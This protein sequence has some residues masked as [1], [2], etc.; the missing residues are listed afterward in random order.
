LAA[1]RVRLGPKEGC[2][3]KPWLLVCAVVA[4]AGSA[5][6]AQPSAIDMGTLNGPGDFVQPLSVGAGAVAWAKFTISEM[7][8]CQ[9]R[10][11]DI[12]VQPVGGFDTEIGLYDS[13]GKR[14]TNDDDDG[15]G[16][17]SAL[18]FGATS[19]LRPLGGDGVPGDGR[20][21]PLPAGTYYLALGEFNTL[22]NDDNWDVISTSEGSGGGCNIHFIIGAG[23]PVND[24]ATQLWESLCAVDAGNLPATARRADGS[25]ALTSIYGFGN[26]RPDIDMYRICITSP[27]TFEADTFLTT[28]MDTILYLFDSTGHGVTLNDNANDTVQSQITAAVVGG[29]GAGVY[30]LAVTPY[31]CTP[32][33]SSGQPL[34]SDTGTG[35]RAADGPGAANPVASWSINAVNDNARYIVSLQGVSFCAAG[36]TC[37][38]ADFNCDGDVGTD[39]DIESFFACL[40]GTCPAPPCASTADFNGDGDVG[41]DGDIEAFFRVLAGGTC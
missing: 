8:R 17:A 24:P 10:Y 14:I 20:D 30:Y 12:V 25:G 41:T 32:L 27:T 36:P 16:V 15:V 35:E 11:L 19:P 37:G 18:S 23:D 34:W 1:V 38:S 6:L 13:S 3:N 31:I 40:A 39:A 9:M 7:S 5:A 21:G 26:N 29:R 28:Q 4:G 2:V 22:F 33:D